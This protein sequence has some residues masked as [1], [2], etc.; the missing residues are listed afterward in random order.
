MVVIKDRYTSGVKQRGRPPLTV[1]DDGRRPLVPDIVVAG[2]V[3]RTFLWE[4]FSERVQNPKRQRRS[5][6]G[7]VQV[8]A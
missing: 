1:R 7:N 5:R 4:M 3:P 8:P 2:P 6:K